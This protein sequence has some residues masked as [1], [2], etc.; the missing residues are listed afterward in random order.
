MSID[1]MSILIIRNHTIMAR[2]VDEKLHAFRRTQIIDAAAECFIEGGFHQTGM[3][4]ICK[5]VGM[6]A[7]SVYH[8]FSNKDA[9][10][11]AI[12]TQFSTDTRQFITDIQNNDSF[13]DGYIQAV[14]NSL[15]HTQKYHRY[16]RLVVEIY[17]ESFRN[18]NVKHIL[19]Q[20]DIEQVKDLQGLI[21]QARTSGQIK[22]THDAQTLAHMLIALMEGLEDR[23]LQY[24]KIKLPKL[25]KVHEDICRNLFSCND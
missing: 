14:S 4:Q 7:G 12:S 10:I 15:K 11:E 18:E 9:I 16:S 24:P 8:Y 22:S 23:V 25:L 17:A 6:S 13:I 2:T 20:L 1:R 5:Q 3:Q 21:E 19:E